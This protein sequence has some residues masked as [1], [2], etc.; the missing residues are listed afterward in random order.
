LNTDGYFQ[1]NNFTLTVNNTH[2]L[3]DSGQIQVKGMNKE[4]GR[5]VLIGVFDGVGPRQRKIFNIPVNMSKTLIN[6]NISEEERIK[7]PP[8][9]LF[10]FIQCKNCAT[11]LNLWRNVAYFKFLIETGTDIK[12]KIYNL[13]YDWT[14]N[15]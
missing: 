3:K 9:I 7:S 1:G 2:Y 13:S 12:T 8:K 6:E 15:I 4:G 14:E 5:E 11:R 10:Y